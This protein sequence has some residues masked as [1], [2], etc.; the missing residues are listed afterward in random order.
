MTGD[1]PGQGWESIVFLHRLNAKGK[2]GRKKWNGGGRS[3]VFHHGVCRD[4]MYPTQKPVSLISEFVQLFTQSGDT[5][6]D[7]FAG[8]GTTLLVADRLGR[9]AIGIE[10]NPEYAQMARDRVYN[11]APLLASLPTRTDGV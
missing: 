6:L 8:A 11:D 3:S 1:R 10:L 5:I 4:A 9:N 2:P 7:P